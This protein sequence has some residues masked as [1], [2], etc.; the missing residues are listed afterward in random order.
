MTFKKYNNAL[1]SGACYA[2]AFLVILILSVPSN[3]QSHVAYVFW[4]SPILAIAGIYF[5]FRSNRLNESRWIGR[6]LIYPG[7]AFLLVLI[8]YLNWQV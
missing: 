3:S 8:I 4:I 5:G 2:I 1:A 7:I 6:A